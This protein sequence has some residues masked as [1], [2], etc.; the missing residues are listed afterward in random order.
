VTRLFCAKFLARRAACNRSIWW[1]ALEVRR[2]V[3]ILSL[4]FPHAGVAE[5]QTRW[6]QNS[7]ISDFF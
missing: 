5:W 7:E 4:R 2:E 6:T 1:E 3:P